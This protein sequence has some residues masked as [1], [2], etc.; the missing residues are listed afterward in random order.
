MTA[1]GTLSQT[2]LY[3]DIANKTLAP[4]VAMF[5]PTYPLWSDAADKTRWIYLPECEPIDSS[6]MDLLDFPVGTRAFKEFRLDGKRL[7]TRMIH[8]FGEGA[9]D[10]LF[11]AYQW[12]DDESEADHVPNGVEDVRGTEHDI[13]D[14]DACHRCHGPYPSGGGLPSRYLGFSALQLSHAGPGLTMAS[15]SA[16]GALTQPAPAG[17]QIPGNSVEK[18]ALG[19]LH[20]NCGNCHNDSANGLLFPFMNT[21]VKTA[22]TLVTQTGTYTTVV[23]Q[24]TEFFVKNPECLWRVNG[25]D[26][27]QSC[28]HHRMGERGSDEM[29]N[30][31]QMPPIGS[32]VVDAVGMAAV[33][34][35]IQSLPP[36]P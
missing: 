35:W 29:K 36:P 3:S 16:S 31:D 8:R 4:V 15:L 30:V 26:L 21:F 17:F 32:D 1:P 24:A 14:V 23:N 11:A 7:E 34:A 25:G 10:Y 9:A 27:Q 18:A 12:R 13:P 33:G 20:A 5:S 22:D 2:G 28:V 19:Y 6:D